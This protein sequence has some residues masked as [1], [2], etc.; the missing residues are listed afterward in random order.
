MQI[1]GEPFTIYELG[2]WQESIDTGRPIHNQN[3]FMKIASAMAGA[4]LG[5][6]WHNPSND[7]H[8]NNKENK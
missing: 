5:W 6:W 1:N 8:I 3:L 7:S 4:V 2:Q